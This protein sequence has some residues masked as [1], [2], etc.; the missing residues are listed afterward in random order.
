[1]SLASVALGTALDRAGVLRLAVAARRKGILPPAG[2]TVVTHHSVTNPKTAELTDTISATP[3]EFD[4]QMAYL[5][6]TFTPV[7]LEDIFEARGGGRKLPADAVLVTFDDGYAD[8]F[9]HALPILRRHGIKAL[10]FVTTGCLTD[11]QLFWWERVNLLVRRS[12]ERALRIEYPSPE[13]IDLSTPAAKEAAKRRLNLIIKTHYDLDLDR[14]LDGVAAACRVPWSDAKGRELGDRVL[15]TW[16][17]VKSLR[18]AGM[19]IGSHSHAHR[20]LQTL[21]PGAL[22]ADLELARALLEGH[23][24]EPV[25]TI[26]YPVGNSIAAEPLIRQAVAASGYELGFTTDAGINTL[27]PGEDP[28]DLRRLMADRELSTGLARL[29]MTFPFLAARATRR[30]TTPEG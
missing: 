7:S 8:N 15:M 28:L 27:A 24:G 16:D 30:S 13:E 17:Q 12:Q 11:R 18:K 23:L 25:R 9:E 14:F 10:F 22:R 21:P 26:A 29:W 2:L 5:R 4:A 20:V 6:Q 19:S 1:M 3:D